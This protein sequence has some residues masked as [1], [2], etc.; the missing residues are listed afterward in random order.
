MDSNSLITAMKELYDYFHNWQQSVITSGV[1]TDK[2]VSPEDR[3]IV[4]AD[5]RYTEG[6]KDALRMLA[7]ELELN[8]DYNTLE[9]K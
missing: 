5:I 7:R 6:A 8:V 3:V 4:N 2:D 1:L 9:K